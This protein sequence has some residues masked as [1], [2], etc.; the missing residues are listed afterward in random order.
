MENGLF[1][2]ICLVIGIAVG[3]MVHMIPKRLKKVL[4]IIG[5]AI[6]IVFGIA[7]IVFMATILSGHVNTS[8]I[9][10]IQYSPDGTHL[11]VAGAIGISFYDM[12]SDKE[13]APLTTDRMGAYSVS[14]SPD[15]QMLAGG[16]EDELI[17]LWDMDT[18]EHKKTFITDHGRNLRVLFSR[19]GNTLASW[20][21]Y[22]ISLW[23]IATS[24]HKKT[25]RKYRDFRSTSSLIYEDFVNVSINAGGGTLVSIGKNNY[26]IRLWDV[27][28]GQEERSLW[29]HTKDVESIA[30]SPDGK[31]LAS[32]GRDKTV[33]LWDVETGEHK[34][35]LTGHRK[36]I[37]GIVF[38]P[39]GQ[40]LASASRDKTIR[41]WDA[42]TGKHKKTLNG[43]TAPVNGAAFSPDGQAIVSWSN[44]QTIR[45]WDVSTGEV[46]KIRKVPIAEE[47]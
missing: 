20:G 18:G 16:C 8:G 44:D 4:F 40:M 6:C 5:I 47:K 43:H 38:S 15:G 11:A 28:T 25:S 36:T 21:R 31:T 34:Q 12:N 32:G 37:D 27:I 24:T 7:F 2:I 23:D 33:R 3:V 35:T 29:G 30:F 9:D 45:L 17:R 13:P 1:V 41:V 46:K 19:D 42:I 22:E 14:F 26:T 10:D 39:D